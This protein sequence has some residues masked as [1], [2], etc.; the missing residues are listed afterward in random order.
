VSDFKITNKDSSINITKEELFK[1]ILTTVF[2]DKDNENLRHSDEYAEAILEALGINTN[3]DFFNI[4]L[5]QMTAISFM[6]GYYYKVFLT[7]NN[8]TIT[9]APKPS[10]E[11]SD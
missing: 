1:N 9:T 8:V 4:T 3:K 11:G 2:K 6:A 5:K 10:K 7:K